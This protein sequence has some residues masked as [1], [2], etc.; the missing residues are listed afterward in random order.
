M[1]RMEIGGDL[2]E[3]SPEAWQAFDYWY[4]DKSYRHAHVVEE[5]ERALR[6]KIANEITEVQTEFREGQHGDEMSSREVRDAFDVAYGI[7]KPMWSDPKND[8]NA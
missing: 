7:A 5:I 8:E 1:K 4:G 6:I 2:Y 3:V